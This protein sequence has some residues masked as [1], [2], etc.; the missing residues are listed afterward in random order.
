MPTQ[1]SLFISNVRHH[2]VLFIFPCHP[3]AIGFWYRSRSLDTP[4]ADLAPLALLIFPQ[5]LIQPPH[6]HLKVIPNN[7]EEGWQLDMLVF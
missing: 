5:T 6:L 2:Y 7:G 4:G 3:L 1:L